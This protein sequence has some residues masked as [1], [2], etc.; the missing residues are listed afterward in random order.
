MT[1]KIL[2][3]TLLFASQSMAAHNLSVRVG[4]PSYSDA[5][6]SDEMS[7]SS[8]GIDLVDTSEIYGTL[9]GGGHLGANFIEHK[10]QTYEL[11]T[12]E[13]YFGPLA[14]INFNDNFSMQARLTL[15][16]IEAK[17]NKRPNQYSWGAG[18]GVG[19]K[20]ALY[21]FTLGVDYQP[22]ISFAK[23]DDINRG[24]TYNHFLL[25]AGYRF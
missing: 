18:Y 15:S 11:K 1:K 20:Y 19:F 9:S 21:N 23:I 13:Y 4:L 8:I 16:Y 25:S 7:G 3:L 10:G 22:F 12:G 24:A 17:W 5:V 6:T 2:A 14:E